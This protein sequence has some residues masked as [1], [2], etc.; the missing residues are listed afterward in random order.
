MSQQQLLHPILF[1]QSLQQCADVLV[2]RSRTCVC[3]HVGWGRALF[4]HI[5]RLSNP[6]T[7]ITRLRQPPRENIE[8]HV[9]LMTKPAAR[10]SHSLQSRHVQH[11]NKDILPPKQSF[12]ARAPQLDLPP[13]GGAASLSGSSAQRHAASLRRT[14]GGASLRGAARQRRAERRGAESRQAGAGG[15]A[16]SRA[17]A[18]AAECETA[19]LLRRLLCRSA[20]NHMHIVSSEAVRLHA[21]SDHRQLLM[22][23]GSLAESDILESTPITGAS[24]AAKRTKAAGSKGG[25]RCIGSRAKAEGLRRL[26]RGRL[27]CAASKAACSRLHCSFSAGQVGQMLQ[28]ASA[29]YTCTLDRQKSTFGSGTPKVGAAEEAGAPNAGVK[30]AP[31]AGVEPAAPNAGAELPK[32]GAAPPPKAAAAELPLPNPLLKLK[33]LGAAVEAAAPPKG[34]DGAAWPLKAKP[35]P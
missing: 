17:A 22:R 27:R 25:R 31:K 35:A 29:A 14:K 7:K 18:G 24:A 11:T 13:C 12:A 4:A 33:P 23:E 2:L 28:Q 32:A 6:N 5:K 9:S 20:C 3:E 15:A 1:R 19:R 26:C 10:R 21:A 16:R 8:S 34:V 30:A